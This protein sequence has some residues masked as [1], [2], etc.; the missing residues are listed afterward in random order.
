MN[1]VGD[2]LEIQF[3]NVQFEYEKDAL[4][5]NGINETIPA[6]ASLAIV[7]HNGCGK[8]TLI[9]LIPRF[10]D[11]NGSASP[12]SIRI[13]GHDVRDYRVKQLRDQVGYVTQQ[14]MLFNDSIA[15]NIAYGK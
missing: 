9:N 12:G 3:D 2:E 10:F 5:L 11:T 8:S 14:T 7:G 13:G 4:I 1:W 15:S 6:G